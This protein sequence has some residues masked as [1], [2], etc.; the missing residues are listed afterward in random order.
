[1]AVLTCVR[2]WLAEP[3]GHDLKSGYREDIAPYKRDEFRRLIR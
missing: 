2:G 3:A 1:M